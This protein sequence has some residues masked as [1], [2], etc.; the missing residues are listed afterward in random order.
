MEKV[1]LKALTPEGETALRS[2]KAKINIPLRDRF[3]YNR[4]YEEKIL[5]ERPFCFSIT[6]KG[7]ILAVAGKVRVKDF[8]S[9]LSIQLAEFGVAHDIDYFIEGK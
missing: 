5:S 7:A 1:I 4:M 8:I 6:P 2:L 3:I 9:E